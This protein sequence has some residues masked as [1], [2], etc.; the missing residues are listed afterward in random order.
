MSDKEDIQ[1]VCGYQSWETLVHFCPWQHEAPST[2]FIC[3]RAAQILFVFP[4]RKK[5]IQ[6]W[7]DILTHFHYSFS[8]A[9]WPALKHKCF[10]GSWK[11]VFTLL[12]SI[13]HRLDIEFDVRN[14]LCVFKLTHFHCANLMGPSIAPHQNR[15]CGKGW[16]II[17][18][19]T[20][21]LASH[22]PGL[23]PLG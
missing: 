7:N 23:N 21:R 19:K 20:A 4:R 9:L 8:D 1:N 15:F 16:S 18:Q 22:F 6:S 3:E 10:R 2:F 13:Y 5:I 11:H 12:M 14:D 17:K